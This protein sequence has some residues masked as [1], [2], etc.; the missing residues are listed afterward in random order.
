MFLFIYCGPNR[1]LAQEKQERF[2]I[3]G[4]GDSSTEGGDYFTCYLFPLWEKLFTAGYEFDFIGPRESKCRIG[5]IK[6]CGFSG[7]TVEFLDS[8]IDSLYRIYPADIVLLHAGGNHFAEEKPVNGMIAAYQSIIQKI[9]NINPKAYILLAK[10]IPNGK[11]PKYAY[12]PELNKRIEELVNQLDND[13]VILVD[14]ATGF[15]WRTNTVADKVHPNKAGAERMA[16]VWIEALKKILLPPK[17]TFQPEIISYKPLANGDSLTLHIFRPQHVK[18]KSSPAIIFFFGGGWKLG[19][20][21]QFY[22]EC[23]YYASKGMVAISA[24]YRIEYLH[25]STP[26]DSFADAQDAIRWLRQ[27]A[28]TY[29]IDPNKIVASGAS[30]GGHLAA[31]L[32]TIGTTN[33]V[34]ADYKPNLLVLYYP[35]VDMNSDRYDFPALDQC[36]RNI[37]PLQN[38]SNNTPP[39]I[40]MVGTK[41]QI[42]SIQTAED[43]CNTIRKKGVECELH[44]FK[45]AGHPIFLY[46]EP[47]TK[48]FYKIRNFTDAFLKRNGFLTDTLN[49]SART[50]K[51]E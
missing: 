14:Q 9:Q 8:K 3:M 48:N 40:F 31:S 4:L 21:L 24:D 18:E 29:N 20:P 1:L 37:S 34:S 16:T 19:T 13:H 38:I 2:T 50:T 42:V 47:L 10:V 17:A 36:Y 5:T 46:R 7:K 15:D 49:T 51:K 35:V 32:G 26:F 23:A 6:H 30:A 44:L 22:R 41:D 12:I 11:L 39:T 43:F 28:A 25:K 27:H 33:E 45:D